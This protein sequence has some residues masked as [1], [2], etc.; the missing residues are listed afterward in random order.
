MDI[1]IMA[2]AI[3]AGIIGIAAAVVLYIRREDEA[4]EEKKRMIVSLANLKLNNE[5]GV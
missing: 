3:F 1:I 2:L 4:Y 5:I